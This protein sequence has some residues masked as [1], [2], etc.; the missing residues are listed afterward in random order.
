MRSTAI[1]TYAG[2]SCPRTSLS[3]PSG[4]LLR[5]VLGRQ[6]RVLALTPFAKIS[7]LHRSRQG[8]LVQHS[9]HR[10]RRVIVLFENRV[11]RVKRSF[12]MVLL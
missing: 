3:G 6:M 12:V 1:E 7:F 11:V 2:T 9:S 4:I 8:T 10:R 5:R